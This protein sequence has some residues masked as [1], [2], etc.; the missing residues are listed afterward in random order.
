MTGLAIET[1]E[2]HTGG[3]PTRII[4]SGYPRLEGRSL[5]DKRREA[6]ARHDRLRRLL[7]REPRG[8]KEMYGALLVEADH[9]DA[10]LAV[11]FLHNEGYSTMCGHAVL[12]LGRY[13]VDHGLVAVREP[14][15]LVRIQCPCGLVPVRVAVAGGK[16]GAARFTSVPSFALAL[17]AVVQ[18]PAWGDLLLDI[19]FGGA[20]YAILPAERLGLDLATTPL[21]HLVEAAAAVTRLTAQQ[22]VIEHPEEAD[23]G[24][25]YGTILTDGRLGRE[26]RASRNL[27][28]FAGDQVDRSPTG[29]GVTARLA[30]MQ[31]RGEAAVGEDHLFESIAGSR[32]KARIDGETRLAGMPAVTVEVEGKAHY[33]GRASFTIEEDDPFPEGFLL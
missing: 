25:L 5:L 18:S 32:F 26:D 17:G 11:L 14:E 28:V 4:L 10:D 15:S 20:F 30:V 31:A 33:S 6:R 29:S 1:L 3:E 19:G 2:M 21:P 13:A 9:P 24:F 27:C 8:H 12:A 23:L 22:I 16:A 7:M